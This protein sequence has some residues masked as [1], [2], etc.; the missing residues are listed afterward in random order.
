MSENGPYQPD[1]A[2]HVEPDEL[3]IDLRE[4]GLVGP[5]LEKLGITIAEEDRIEPFD[6]AKLKLAY[7][8]GLGFEMAIDPVLAELRRRFAARCGGWVPLLGKNRTLSNQFGAYPQTRSQSDFDPSPAD[9]PAGT[10]AGPAAGHGVR[11]GILDTRL[12]RHPDLEGHYETPAS[13]T[14]FETPAPGTETPWEDGHATF[15]AGLILA[16]APAAT[17]VVRDVLKSDGRAPV[18]AT[19]GKLAEFLDDDIDILNLAMGTR[20]AQ[21]EDGDCPV[22]VRRAIERLSPHMVIVAAAGNHGEIP[23]L[24]N[25]LTRTAPTWP[26]ALTGVVAVGA[27]RANGAPA[28][29]SPDLPW[30]SC[31]AL[32]DG[33][34]STYLPGDVRLR[35]GGVQEF[36]GYATWKGT[37][38]ATATVSGAIAA[39]T[40]RG[41]VTAT[42]AFHAALAAGDVVK[43][44]GWKD[45][46][47][48]G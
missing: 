45:E 27:T 7:P 4:R 25:G 32:G 1:A 10:G 26:A 36:H 18:W 28:P 46:A 37:S 21:D 39:G 48:F 43:P 3:I 12:Y 8:E 23:G 35:T 11:V 24:R 40:K 2:E 31:T 41:E 47:V 5:A 16:Q 34:T 19:V 20:A 14:T 15:V 6:L 42:E 22:A 44:Y 29:Y 9:R 13:G 33:L 17:L 38:F 30:V